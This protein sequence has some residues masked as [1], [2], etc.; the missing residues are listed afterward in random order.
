MTDSDETDIPEIDV[1]SWKEAP[2]A[3]K[4]RSII[5]K[6]E[7]MLKKID[8]ASDTVGYKTLSD[9]LLVLKKAIILENDSIADKCE[10]TLTAAIR[11]LEKS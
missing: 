5:R 4:Y 9:G 8:S 2:G 6:A 3:S 11:L 7:R 10:E 1:E